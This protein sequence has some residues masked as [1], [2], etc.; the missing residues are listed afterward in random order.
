M[1]KIKNT[2]NERA[3]KWLERSLPKMID[4]H[5]IPELS[6]DEKELYEWVEVQAKE[7]AMDRYHSKID[8]LTLTSYKQGF[9]RGFYFL[10]NKLNN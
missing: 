4:E 3:F 7:H 1:G 8:D 2:V 6:K 5:D 9:I 10:Y